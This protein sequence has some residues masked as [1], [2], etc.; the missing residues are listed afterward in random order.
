MGATRLLFIA[1]HS[2]IKHEI[3]FHIIVCS[4]RTVCHL[5][6]SRRFHMHFSRGIIISHDGTKENPIFRHCNF[7]LASSR[8]SFCSAQWGDA[9]ADCRLWIQRIVQAKEYSLH[10]FPRLLYFN[11]SNKI[12][13]TTKMFVVWNWVWTLD[14]DLYFGSEGIIEKCKPSSLYHRTAQL[15]IGFL[16]Y[17]PLIIYIDIW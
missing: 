10:F 8:L 1:I 13:K 7:K 14:A 6:I 2:E 17:L 16:K 5:L 3:T 15:L 9:F 4:H 11:L 12:Y